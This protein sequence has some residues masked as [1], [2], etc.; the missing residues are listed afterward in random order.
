MYIEP[1]SMQRLISLK[2]QFS[3]IKNDTIP[4]SPFLFAAQVQTRESEV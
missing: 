1:I 3:L 4:A 2:T